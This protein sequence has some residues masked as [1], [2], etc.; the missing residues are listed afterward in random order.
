MKKI[1]TKLPWFIVAIML[2]IFLL[3]GI[4]LI[5]GFYLCKKNRELMQRYN[6]LEKLYINKITDSEE[7]K[8]KFL[9]IDDIEE[10]Q[11]LTEEEVKSV[12][13]IGYIR[14]VFEENN[15]KYIE[16][17][18]ID[19][20]QGEAARQAMVADEECADLETCIVNNDY[21]IQNT[22]TSTFALELSDSATI[23]M[24]TYQILERGGLTKDEKITYKQFEDIFDSESDS[25][26][27]YAPYHL[28]IN[29]GIV[30]SV[31]EQY[32]P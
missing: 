28:R 12:R 3:L 6:F 1:N 23:L 22:D 27:K 5:G 18:Y 21:Y 20:L 11:E 29:D 15:K 16:V 30:V 31:T 26:T 7:V 9:N 19:W 4:V 13:K 32:V 17:D 25:S 10:L 2:G 24:Q 14:R 8:Q